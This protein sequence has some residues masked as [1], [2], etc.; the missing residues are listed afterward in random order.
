MLVFHR[1]RR[2]RFVRR[3]ARIGIAPSYRPMQEMKPSVV[4][5]GGKHVGEQQSN[6][7]L[8]VGARIT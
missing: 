2:C 6:Q 8:V 7:E 5:A 4:Y 1:N 3:R